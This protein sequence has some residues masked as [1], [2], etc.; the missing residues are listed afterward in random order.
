MQGREKS[1]TGRCHTHFPAAVLLLLL[2]LLLL[3]RRVGVPTF[4]PRS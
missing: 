3:V 2:L 4:P 1:E